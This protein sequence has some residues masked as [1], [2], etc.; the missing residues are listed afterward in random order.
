MRLPAWQLPSQ[1]V[2]WLKT[3]PPAVRNGLFR[4]LCIVTPVLLFLAFFNPFVLDPTRIG[5]LMIA[6]WGQHVL[7]WNAFRHTPWSAGNHEYLL[8]WPTGLPVIYT[9]SNPLFA[10]IFKPF[11]DFLPKDFQYIG[12]WFLFCVCLHFVFAWKL[13]RPH[14]PGRW[15]GLGGAI[16]LSALPCLYYRMRHDTL[17][18]QWLI[19]WAL[20]LVVNVRAGTPSIIAEGTSRFKSL[21][22]RLGDFFDAKTRGWIA[23]LGLTGM[24]HPY[25]LFMVVVIWGGDM[26]RYFWPAARA[27]D[28]RTLALVVCRGL[29]TF[30]VPLLTMGL[31]GAY[32]TGQSPGAGGWSY[33]SAGLDSFFNPV[34][35]DFSNFLRAWP[36]SP[37]QAF[38]GYQYLGFGLLVLIVAAV[39]LYIVT[40]EAKQSRAFLGSLKPLIIPFVILAA[41]AL[42]NRVQAFGQTLLYFDLPPATRNVLAIL[43]ASGRFLWPI[44]YCMVFAALVVLYKSRQRTLAAV[45]P[46]VLILQAVDLNGFAVTM[47]EAT[48][49]AAKPQTYY[50]TPSP[51]WDK[52]VA[53]S[54]GVDFYPV[55]VH[56]NDKLFYELTWRATSQAKPVNTMYPA[57]EN[58][59]QIAHM[60]ADQDAFK[61]GQVRNDR[62]FVF[63]KQCDAPPELQSRLRMLDGVW[64]IP[65]DGARDLPLDKPQWSPLSSEV[66]FGWLDQGTCLLDENWSQPEYDGTWTDG[67]KAEVQIPIK[68]VQFDYANPRAL[69]LHLKA[70]SFRPVLVKV[71][72]NGRKVSELSLTRHTSEQTI[73]LPASV[74][75]NENMSIRF[76]VE[77]PDGEPVEIA[78]ADTATPAAGGGRSAIQAKPAP[79]MKAETRELAIKLMD[80]RLVDRDRQ[81]KPK[82]VAIA[83]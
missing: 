4:G 72:V 82:T 77:R 32:T 49:L 76:V 81:P 58:L 21:L 55:N 45:L 29:V 12:P 53:R 68:H 66:R 61:R 80:L 52:L 43:R 83:G 54:N 78:N 1:A 11:R 50:L 26:L 3:T 79:D 31:A 27:L 59:I 48:S 10:F 28:R 73:P 16:A 8:Y 24:I 46:A 25:I 51:L 62:L 30:A 65:P 2:N 41:F 57:R 38:E 36:Q 39:I 69:D 60:Q 35:Q 5:W 14:A 44:G 34:V 22:I 33:Y 13:V 63:L 70:K 23:L 9:D 40:P 7:G 17:M 47:R 18:A 56:F 75:R 67:P 6:D 71:I 20:H 42:T 74:L 19:L 15:S 64:I 37:G